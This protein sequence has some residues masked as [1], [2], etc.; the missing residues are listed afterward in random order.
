MACITSEP[1]LGLAGCLSTSYYTDCLQ[2]PTYPATAVGLALAVLPASPQYT[3]L[4]ISSP[5]S[6]RVCAYVCYSPAYEW[7]LHTGLY[8]SYVYD[9]G[10]LLAAELCAVAHVC[11]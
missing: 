5:P 10:V 8:I 1:S 4:F 2:A 9:S 7:D 3:L 11:A 6:E